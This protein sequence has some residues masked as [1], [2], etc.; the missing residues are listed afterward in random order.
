MMIASSLFYSLHITPTANTLLPTQL[1][2]TYFPP[3]AYLYFSRSF[4]TLS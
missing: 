1:L 2:T 4:S 3:Y